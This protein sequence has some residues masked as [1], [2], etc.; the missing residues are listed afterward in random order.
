MTTRIAVT[1]KF[2]VSALLTIHNSEFANWYSHGVWWAIYGDFQGQGIYEDRYLI[3]NVLRNIAQGWY[4]QPLSGAL[5]S[6]GF[7]L[8][9]IHGGNI[10]PK[11]HTLRQVSSIVAL[12]DK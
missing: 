12:T 1:R 4:N 2:D 9:M 6:S 3:D 8:G 7:Y 11:S 10:T 5:L